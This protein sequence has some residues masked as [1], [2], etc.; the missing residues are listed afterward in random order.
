LKKVKFEFSAGGLVFKKKKVLMI[1]VKTLQ[2]K[3][4]WTFPK[5]HLEP[6]ETAEEAALREVKEETGYSCGIL[7]KIGSSEY[8]FTHMGRTVRKNVKWFLM[9]PCKR[10]AN[11][12]IEALGTKWFTFPEAKNKSAYKLDKILL[13]ELKNTLNHE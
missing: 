1:R 7:K 5:G 2:G 3:I 10:I 12:T 6:G 4:V 8:F 9:K 13:K 11:T